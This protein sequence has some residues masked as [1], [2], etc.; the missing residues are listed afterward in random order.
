MKTN[1]VCLQKTSVNRMFAIGCLFAAIGFATTLPDID[2]ENARQQAEKSEA[3][4]DTPSD[5][6]GVEAAIAALVDATVIRADHLD[7]SAITD[8]IKAWFLTDAFLKQTPIDVTTLN[9]VVTLS[10]TVTSEQMAGRAIGLANSLEQVKAVH[11][12]MI[13]NSQLA[14]IRQ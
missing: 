8:K 10:G 9:G 1:R 14:A 12:Q 2:I 4:I 7:D 5:L 13:I 6:M 11:N 3:Y